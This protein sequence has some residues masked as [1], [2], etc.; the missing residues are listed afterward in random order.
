MVRNLEDQFTCK[1][2][3]RG[4]LYELGKDP[5]ML[6]TVCYEKEYEGI[7][8]CLMDRMSEFMKETED[9]AGV[10]FERIREVY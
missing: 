4:E 7:K 5:W 2:N 3:E 10:W 8:R 1:E 6:K 9:P